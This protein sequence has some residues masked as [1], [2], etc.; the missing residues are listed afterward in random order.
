MRASL[1]LLRTTVRQATP[2]L[3]LGTAALT[4]VLAACSDS[5]TGPSATATATSAAVGQRTVGP[6]GPAYAANASTAQVLART[7]TGDTVHTTIRLTPAV[8][9]SSAATITLGN[10]SK[11][12]F[13]AGAASVCDSTAGYGPTLWNT[14]CKPATY[15]INVSAFTYHDAKTG[16]L[17]SQFHPALRFVPNAAE[18]VRLYLQDQN[19]SSRDAIWFCP[20]D[21]SAC[22]NESVTDPSVATAYDASNHWV[23]RILKHFSGYTVLV[24]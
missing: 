21:G 14:A 9:G 2:A 15:A 11:I 6:S 20:D 12:V 17:V 16:K 5:P 4:A 13:P 23:Y 24:N 1:A 3:A 22:V 10:G 18:P 19:Y 8:P 7:T